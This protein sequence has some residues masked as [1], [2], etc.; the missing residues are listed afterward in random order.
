LRPS[1]PPTA[2]WVPI[3]AKNALT[4]PA[5]E[6]GQ[7]IHSAVPTVL[8]VGAP[9]QR[10]GEDGIL[11]AGRQQVLPPA[12]ATAVLG[13]VTIL[14]QIRNLGELSSFVGLRTVV[15]VVLVVSGWKMYRLE[16]R[17]LAIGTAILAML[18]WF[19]SYYPVG[20]AVGIWLLVTLS[21]P[22]VRGA[23]QIKRRRSIDLDE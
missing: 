14:D 12:I 7:Q 17:G 9:F 2:D 23:F 20:L 5:Q 3:P 21:A 11:R 10:R 19:T 16:A 18:P 4:P 8:P 1:A 13:I 22:K 6:P 15:A